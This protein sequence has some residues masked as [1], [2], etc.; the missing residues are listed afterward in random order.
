MKNNF[1]FKEITQLNMPYFNLHV[2]LQALLKKGE[3]T[4][5]AF[6]GLS[7]AF[8][9]VDHQI[10]LKSYSIIEMIALH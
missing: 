8:D 1:V 9:T 10:L 7:K 4:L 5:G 2:I 3:Y 6:I